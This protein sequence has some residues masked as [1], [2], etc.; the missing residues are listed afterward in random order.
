MSK[1]FKK[2][3]DD[4]EVNLETSKEINDRVTKFS[5]SHG[6]LQ[7]DLCILLTISEGRR[8]IICIEVLPLNIV[9]LDEIISCSA[10]SFIKKSINDKHKDCKTCKVE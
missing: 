1:S 8:D 6:V 7:S 2:I 3:N 4:S 5:P 9:K 10:Y